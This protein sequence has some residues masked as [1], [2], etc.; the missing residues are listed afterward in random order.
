MSEAT[1]NYYKLLQICLEIQNIAYNILIIEIIC[2]A[3]HF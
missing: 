1:S 2:K 3:K